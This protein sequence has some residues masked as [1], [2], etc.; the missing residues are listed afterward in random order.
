[1]FGEVIGKIGGATVPVE[2][3][4][5]FGDA[6]QHCLTVSLARMLEAGALFV[7]VGMAGCGCLIY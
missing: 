6:V 5:A 3:E 1:M 7:W 4:L 2:K